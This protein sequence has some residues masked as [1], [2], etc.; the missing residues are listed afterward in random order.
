[1][2]PILTLFLCRFRNPS[3]RKD[4]RIEGAD[5]E[6]RLQSDEV[7]YAVRTGSWGCS[8]GGKGGTVVVGLRS[9]T[10]TAAVPGGDSI[11]YLVPG[12]WYVVYV[13]V[14]LSIASP[15]VH[16]YPIYES[17]RC[18]CCCYCCC[19]FR[20]GCVHVDSC[21]SSYCWFDLFVHMAPVRIPSRPWN[22][23]LA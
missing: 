14:V 21:A 2:V 6:G 8:G 3:C 22:C 9:C 19:C 11:K 5:A 23:L 17:G 16:R 10:R 18:C 4:C 20:C 12:M 15:V 1:M 13:D 7:P